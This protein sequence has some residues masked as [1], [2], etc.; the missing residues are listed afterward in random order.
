M[1]L[2]HDKAPTSSVCFPKDNVD[3]A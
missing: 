3:I 1:L 2:T